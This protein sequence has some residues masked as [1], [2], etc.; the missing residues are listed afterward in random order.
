[1]TFTIQCKS[2]TDKRRN[3]SEEEDTG[4]KERD[5]GSNKGV[6]EEAVEIGDRDDLKLSLRTGADEQRIEIHLDGS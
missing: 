4:M 2:N 6:E 5:L 3:I 1:M